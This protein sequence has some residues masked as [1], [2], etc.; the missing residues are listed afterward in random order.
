MTIFQFNVSVLPGN[1]MPGSC[2]LQLYV[3]KFVH[4]KMLEE[5][6]PI[7]LLLICEFVIF[8]TLLKI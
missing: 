8:K 6:I 1:T 7:K 2:E 5:I 3:V 4:L